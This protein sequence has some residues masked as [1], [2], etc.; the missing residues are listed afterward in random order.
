V[1]GLSCPTVLTTLLTVTVPSVNRNPHSVLHRECARTQGG[2]HRSATAGRMT[3]T[4]EA[5]T[6]P[7]LVRQ[8]MEAKGLTQAEVA[9]ASG[10]SS[11]YI[12]ML[13]HEKRGRRPS[14]DAVDSIC[15]GLHASE[16]ERAALLFASGYA[17]TP[18]SR[19]SFAE[20]VAADP[21]LSQYAKD[22]LL[23]MY[24]ALRQ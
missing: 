17:V 5:V 15:Q 10:R 19:V 7:V 11:G 18:P 22:A 23:V 14:R 24:N 2:R 4:V 9:S 1:F 21:E 12:S 6:F 16:K 3:L 20:V 8:I 13:V